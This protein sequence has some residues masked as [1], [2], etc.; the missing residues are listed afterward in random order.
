MRQLID[1]SRYRVVSSS[2]Y[3]PSKRKTSACS[4]KILCG[5]RD[6]NHMKNRPDEVQ[7]KVADFLRSFIKSFVCCPKRLSF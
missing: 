2:H 3:R 4:S 5:A 7:E 1:Y 6:Q